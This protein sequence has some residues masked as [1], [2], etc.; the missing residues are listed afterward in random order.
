MTL[1]DAIKLIVDELIYAEET[2]PTFPTDP[3]HAVAK[4]TE[5]AGEA[6]QAANDLVYGGPHAG[7]LEGELKQAGAMAL[8][9]LINMHKFKAR[10]SGVEGE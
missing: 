5:E 10:R 3:I 6:A 2:Y 9:N 4:L 8:R 7:K 1:Y